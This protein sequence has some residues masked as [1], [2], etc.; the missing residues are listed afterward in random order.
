[1]LGTDSPEIG[2]AR[3]LLFNRNYYCAVSISIGPF[4]KGIVLNNLLQLTG[5]P[6]ID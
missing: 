5:S 2:D 3:R 6:L 1:M 4:M